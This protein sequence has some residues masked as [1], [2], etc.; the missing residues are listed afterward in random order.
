[1]AIEY[2]KSDDAAQV[3]A[4]ENTPILIDFTASNCAPCMMMAPEVESFAQNNPQIRVFSINADY[5]PAAAAHFR[6]RIFPMMHLVYNGRSIAITA[7]FL[8]EAA[9]TEFVQKALANI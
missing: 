4:I 5:F 2:L 6:V 8:D 7:G 1:M 3:L 9:I